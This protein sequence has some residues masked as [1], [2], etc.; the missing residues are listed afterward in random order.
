MANHEA[1][2]S[3]KQTKKLG[4]KYRLK[5]PMPRNVMLSAEHADKARRIGRGNL[6]A[7]VRLAV[8]EYKEAQG[9]SSDDHVRGGA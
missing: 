5:H 9:A 8:E 2:N 7:G 3:M 4:P 6:S 1:I